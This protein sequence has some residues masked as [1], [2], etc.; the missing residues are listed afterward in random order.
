[1]PELRRDPV[2]G[3]WVIIS[4]GPHKRRVDFHTSKYNG[5]T[6]GKGCPFCPG[7]ES[8]TPREILAFREPGSQPNGPGWRVRVIPNKFPAL[9]VE[10]NLD[11]EGVG[12]YDRMNGV[13]AHEIVIESPEHDDVYAT[14]SVSRLEEIFRAFRDRMVDLRGD[15]RF[16]YVMV[17]KNY[18]EAAGARI[19]HPHSQLIALPVLPKHIVE[20]MEG[21][22]EYYGYKE[23]CIFCDIVQQELEQ[24]E[25]LIASNDGFLA[26]CP[27]APKFPFEIWIL[28]RRHD[29]SYEDSS[30]EQFAQLAQ[31]V[32]EV[33]K[34]LDAALDRPHYNSVIHT[35]PYEFQQN[36]YYHW[37]IEI[38]PRIARVA[39]F[40][41]G[42]G[43]YINSVPPEESAEFLLKVKAEV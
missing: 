1:M 20:E 29:S 30:N 41:Y 43:F 37:H 19:E 24:E 34:R 32:S 14:L 8:L 6:R 27:W 36:D 21:S 22:K 38:M 28:P 2:D 33:H 9:S 31:V 18:G 16:R 11:R 17:F 3:R 40:E 13:G 7:N 10:G 12:Y 15:K 39:G 35:S 42:T 4:T 5:S 26:I 25:R 23:R